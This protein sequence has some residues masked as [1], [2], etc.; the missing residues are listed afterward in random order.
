VTMDELKK[1]SIEILTE[2]MVR[3]GL[4]QGERRS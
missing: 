4:L 2:G 3:L 1:H